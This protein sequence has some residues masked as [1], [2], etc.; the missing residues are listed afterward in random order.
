MRIYQTNLNFTDI[1]RKQMKFSYCEWYFKENTS[2]YSSVQ[3]RFTLHVAHMLSLSE[4]NLYGEYVC[5]ALQ[6]VQ[7]K[8]L[9]ENGCGPQQKISIVA[10]TI[11]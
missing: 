5:R 6:T 4:P 3:K 8:T 9:S 10:R 1:L 7:Y 2:Y 11:D